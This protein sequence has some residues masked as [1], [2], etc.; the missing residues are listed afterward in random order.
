MGGA[1]LREKLVEIEA[2]RLVI[3]V[4]ESKPV[5]R[6]GMRAPVP[7]EIVRFGWH[8]TR[9]RL[10][11]LG[12]RPALRGG[13]RQPFTTDGGNVI[14]DCSFESSD[15]A[16]LARDIK[17]TTGVV[18]HGFFLGMATDLVVGRADGSV[19]HRTRK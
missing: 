18:E 9:E 13:E 1:L 11:A 4:D 2:A 6:L 15:V 12:L 19:E 17:A 14:C 7:V 8:T 5:P 16:T 3:M 10:K